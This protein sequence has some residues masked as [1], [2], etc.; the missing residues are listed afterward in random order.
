M[1]KTNLFYLLVAMKILLHVV[2]YMDTIDYFTKIY[3]YT[4]I[5]DSSTVYDVVKKYLNSMKKFHSHGI[6]ERVMNPV[7]ANNRKEQK[8]LDSFDFEM[9]HHYVMNVMRRLQDM[10]EIEV[11]NM[12]G[13]QTVGELEDEFV[14]YSFDIEVLCPLWLL[15]PEDIHHVLFW[16][17]MAK[18]VFR[19]ICR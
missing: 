2:A 1:M 13:L 10:K 7:K 9:E 5:N 8:I 4:G 11:A 18:L 14:K 19:R 17:D 3:K 12:F 6:G 15:V 16:C